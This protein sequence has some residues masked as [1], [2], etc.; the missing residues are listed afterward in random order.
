MPSGVAADSPPSQPRFTGDLDIYVAPTIENDRRFIDAIADF[1]FPVDALSAEG[2][3][4]PRRVIEMGIPP[5]PIHVMSAIVGV[6]WAEVLQGTVPGHFDGVP[7]SFIGREA[8]L[9]NKRAA[10]RPKD[11]AD[12]AALLDADRQCSGDDLNLGRRPQH[13]PAT[14]A[15]KR[16]ALDG[17]P[18]NTRRVGRWR[19]LASVD[20]SDGAVG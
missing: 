19:C 14:T 12:V 1:G 17:A 9:K 2:V 18:G 6:T 15:T 13:L 20:R 16:A 8:F 10:G 3:I 7:V 5:I 11:I 4:D